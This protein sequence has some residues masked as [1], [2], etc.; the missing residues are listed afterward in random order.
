MLCTITFFFFN[1]TATT[2]IYT[3]SLHDALPISRLGP[4]PAG[5]PRGNVQR[6][7][8]LGGR[9]HRDA[10]ARR[11]HLAAG[12]GQQVRRGA[13][14]RAGRRHEARRS[15][16]H[17]LRRGVDLPRLVRGQARPRRLRP[18]AQGRRVPPAARSAAEQRRRLL[19][20][21]RLGLRASF[22]GGPRAHAA[23]LRGRVPRARRRGRLP[24][25]TARALAAAA[26]AGALACGG[27][28]H[29]PTVM[30]AGGTTGRPDQG[31][32]GREGA[33]ALVYFDLKSTGKYGDVITRVHTPVARQAQLV[34]GK[35]EPLKRLEVPGGAVV[36][37][38]PTRPHVGP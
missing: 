2:E 27:C 7:P 10:R 35:G 9:R 32:A 13:A 1:D 14:A 38:T 28:V 31:A 30:E 8:D 24:L 5:R 26:L 17:V 21:P 6:Q 37:F 36:S 4:Q 29:Y 25:V 22:P 3:L 12:E 23:W 19:D 33:G 11:R 15:A 34:S 20:E 16:G 18:A